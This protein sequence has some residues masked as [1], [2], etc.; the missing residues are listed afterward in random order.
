VEIQGDGGGPTTQQKAET[1]P[2]GLS[3]FPQKPYKTSMEFIYTLATT[4]VQR[5]PIPDN[6]IFIA[7]RK[8]KIVDV[9][10]GLIRHNFL[11]VPVLQAK[12]SKYY[13]FLD[14]ADIVKYVVDTFGKDMVTQM[15]ENYWE[16]VEKQEFFREKTVND[17][18]VYPLSRRNPFHPVTRGYSLFSA[19]ELLARERGLHRVP[20][21]DENRKL[22]HLVTQSQVVLYLHQNIH[23][24]GEVKNKPAGLVQNFDVQ[25]LAVREDSFIMEAF[26]LMLSRNVTGLAVVNVEGR[27]VGNLSL[28]DLKA[29]QN[30]ARMFWRLTETVKKFHRQVEERPN[31]LAT[32]FC[33]EC[34]DE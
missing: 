12:G 20:V 1:V 22:V 16:F 7:Q 8:D 32:S 24:L 33:R 10:K 27:L 29:V 26:D 34:Q 11:S 9:W 23:A 6:K 13:G 15:S 21:I 2:R 31:G 28:R 4:P 18:M 5:L 17:L 19:I 3:S 30:D 25:V 14:L